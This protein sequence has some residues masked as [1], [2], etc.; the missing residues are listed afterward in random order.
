MNFAYLIVYRPGI[1]YHFR[2]RI[3]GRLI[4]QDCREPARSKEGW[5]ALQGQATGENTAVIM[6]G[7][8]FQFDPAVQSDP[9]D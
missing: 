7:Q 4:R 1:M 9:F 6:G 5:A 2:V 8:V 3:Q